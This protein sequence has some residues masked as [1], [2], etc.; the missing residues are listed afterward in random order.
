MVTFHWVQL[1]LKARTHR[2]IFTESAEESAIESADSTAE[3]ANSPAD[4]MI[5]IRL[6]LSNMFAILNPLESGVGRLLE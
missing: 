3:S 5:V 2:P 1:T 6:A 4:S